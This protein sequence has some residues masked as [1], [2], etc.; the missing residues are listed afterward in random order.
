MSLLSVKSLTKRFGGLTALDHLSIEVAAGEVVGIIGPNGSGKTTFFNVLTG[1][2]NANDGEIYLDGHPS[3]LLDM[4][5]HQIISLGISRTFQNQRP[6]NN[7]SVLENLMVGGHCRGKGGILSALLYLPGTRK[8]RGKLRKRSRVVMSL[9][10]DRLISM[11]NE[12][13]WTLSYANRR[14]LEIARAL[15]SGPRI[16]LLD[17]PTAGMNPAESQ[18]LVQNILEINKGGITVLVIEHDMNFIKN[19]CQRVIAMDY[20]KKIVEGRYSEVRHH[21]K[22]IEAYLGK[23]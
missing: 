6:F 7:L 19:L 4:K 14:R 23:D 15:V 18:Q 10:G 20:G 21:P 12:P 9:F 17:E 3:N 8:D 11:E 13:A 22:V 1:M 5:T 2:Y 16:L